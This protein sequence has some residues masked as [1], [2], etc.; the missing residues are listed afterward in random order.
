MTSW[1]D[2]IPAIVV[3]LAAFLG[4]I[5]YARH[6]LTP[7]LIGLALSCAIVWASIDAFF[8][9]FDVFDLPFGG[10]TSGMCLLLLAILLLS[11]RMTQGRRGFE[12]IF[13]LA[14]MSTI[15]LTNL[16]FHFVLFDVL[17]RQWVHDS[18]KVSE[19]PLAASMELMPA[20]CVS[21]MLTC[22]SKP[23]EAAEANSDAGTLFVLRTRDRVIL[24]GARSL[25][26]LSEPFHKGQHN[27]LAAYHVKDGQ[28][29]ELKNSISSGPIIQVINVS[30]N[31][32]SFSVG[33]VW[34]TGAL[35]LTTFH[36]RRINDRRRLSTL[37]G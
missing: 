15:L 21:V 7:P 28:L 18:L 30:L 29:I 22:S 12:R 20:K 2:L 35:Y 8:L 5:I 6:R 19:V 4:L 33:F 32:L 36:R 13:I 23:L 14:C 1:F 37:R 34:I 24:E 11:W 3:A 25:Y 27:Y 17:G 9:S 16:L 31:A 26:A 10:Q